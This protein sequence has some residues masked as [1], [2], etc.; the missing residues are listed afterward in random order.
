VHLSEAKSLR[1][2]PEHLSACGLPR[3]VP[4]VCS[5]PDQARGSVV[6]I[7]RGGRRL[8][9]REYIGQGGL[10]SVGRVYRLTSAHWR[11]G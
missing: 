4:F 8:F 11:Q 3:F 2:R 6:I 10:E 1:E 7:K 5:Q 9:V